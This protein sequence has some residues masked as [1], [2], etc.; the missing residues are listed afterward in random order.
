MLPSKKKWIQSSFQL[1]KV[2]DP[3]SFKDIHMLK[4][5]SKQIG[6]SRMYGLNTCAR[7]FHSDE[8]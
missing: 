2:Q 3:Q 5:V 8:G 1:L 4:E 6:C 7:T